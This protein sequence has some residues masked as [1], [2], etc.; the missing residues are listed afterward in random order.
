MLLNYIN[1]IGLKYLVYVVQL[2]K[3]RKKFPYLASLNLYLYI[4]KIK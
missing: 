3:L 2:D 1:A 4:V